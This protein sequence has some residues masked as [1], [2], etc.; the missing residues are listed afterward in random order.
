M[1]VGK[2]DLVPGVLE[3]LGVAVHFRQVRMKPGKPLLFGTKGDTL[4]FGLPGNPVSAFVC[5]ELFVR[6]ALR[7]LAGHADPGPV[8]TSLPLAEGIAEAN[9]RPTYRPAKLE[10]GDAGYCGAPAAVARRAGPPRPA[11]GRR[12]AR[13]AAGRTRLAAGQLA[14]VVSEIT[15]ETQD[16]ERMKQS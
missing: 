13:A 5:F 14:S 11:T 10:L 16:T 15:A 3:E 7:V 2:F 6:P 4:V 1:S 8:T 9:D 12:A